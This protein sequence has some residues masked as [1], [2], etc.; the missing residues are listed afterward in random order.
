VENKADQI[1]KK[2]FQINKTGYTWCTNR[3]T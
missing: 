1:G 3:W 2:F